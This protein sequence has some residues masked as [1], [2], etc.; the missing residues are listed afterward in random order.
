[1]RMWLNIIVIALCAPGFSAWAGTERSLF[2]RHG[3]SLSEQPL[4]LQYAVSEA[5]GGEQHSYHL[6]KQSK[7]WRADTPSQDY[8]THFDREGF[9]LSTGQSKFHMRA[10]AIGYGDQREALPE[11]TLS[12]DKNRIEYTRG[13]VTEWYVNGPM[14]LQQ[15]FT[16]AAAPQ[17][18]GP[19][20]QALVLSLGVSGNLSP[21]VAS[22][23]RS[24][25]LE[26]DT[27]QHVLSYGGLIAFDVLGKDLPAQ[28]HWDGE[29][30]ELWVDDRNAT[31]PTKIISGNW[32][33]NHP[34]R[35][36]RSFGAGQTDT[37]DDDTGAGDISTTS[38]QDAPS[39][40]QGGEETGDLGQ[41][42]ADDRGAPD[43][44]D[45]QDDAGT[46]DADEDADADA[47]ADDGDEGT[48]PP[49]P[50]DTQPPVFS[51]DPASTSDPNTN[52]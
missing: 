51:D 14:G 1:M 40:D 34:N 43:D 5:V 45:A 42:D 32:T 22:D 18:T 2:G 9:T 48:E 20:G 17:H 24:V 21:E 12:T 29:Q 3:T 41:Q 26:T 52:G 4:S 39:D 11:A 50:A 28:M 16:L 25:T 19:G 8:S 10:L 31:Y 37:T 15:G 35:A 49:P 44:A 6:R 13:N 23:G 30:L 7:G 36:S 46:Q 47:D 38:S 27:G 33:S